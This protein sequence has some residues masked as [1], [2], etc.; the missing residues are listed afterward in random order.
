[1]ENK[2]A[3]ITGATSG[4]GA[5]FAR[6]FAAQGYSLILTGRRKEK[7]ESFSTE[8]MEKYQVD[9]EV[10]LAEL[11]EESVLEKMVEKTKEE[12]IHVLV[13][14]AGFGINQ[15]FYEGDL[16]DYT[17][18]VRVHN[19]VPMELIYA[20]L[21]A[22]I[23]RDAGIIINVCS[24]AVFIPVQ[25]NAVYSATKSF[26]KSF[27]ECLNMDLRNTGVKVQALCPG[28]TH[29]DLHERMGLEKSRQKDH[30]WIHWTTSQ[31]VVNQS[32]EDIRRG[33]LISVPGFRT[34]LMIFLLGLMPRRIYYQ[35]L[36][37]V[38]G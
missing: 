19:Q 34:R 8:L 38:L 20:V 29:T 24:E 30:G 35:F 32:L 7:L 9:V 11:A 31:E 23:S 13:N 16:R 21:P 10:I 2:T 5:E 33:N 36:S 26:L 6:R 3:L 15:L 37:K 18:M 12:N 22:M 4:I 1:M 17:K 28:L 27:T 25:K 14:N